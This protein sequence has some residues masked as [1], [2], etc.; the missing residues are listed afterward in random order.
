MRAR[1]CHCDRVP[2]PGVPFAAGKGWC[3]RC[4]LYHNDSR[5]RDLWTPKPGRAA[6]VAARIPPPKPAPPIRLPCVHEGAVKSKCPCGDES[7]DVRWCELHK[8]GVK[9]AGVCRTCGDYARRLPAPPPTVAAAGPVEAAAYPHAGDGWTRHLLWFCY[10][11]ANTSVWQCNVDQLLERIALFN[12]RRVCA[13]AKQA[14]KVNPRRESRKRRPAHFVDPPEA[15]RARL[16]GHRFEF[17]EIDNDLKLGEVAAFEPLWAMVEPFREPGDVTFYYHAK[18]VTRPVNPGVSVHPW[19]SALYGANLDHWPLVAAQLK[20]HPIVGA[21]KKLGRFGS[22]ARMHYSGTAYWFRNAD[23]FARDWRRIDRIYAGV[24]AWPGVQFTPDEMGCVFWDNAGNL[25]D[26]AYLRTA[27]AAYR[28]WSDA[29][30]ARGQRRPG[31]VSN[32]WFAH[33]RYE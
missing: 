6:R 12:G 33:H 11:V 9:R 24:E 16:A 20:A 28:D 5:Y 4:D 30:A 32:P 22:A 21:F 18:G 13:I 1:P 29:A 7:R 14:G 26:F 23:V 3:R 25:Y 8:A 31:A 17:V 27:L 15:V 10:P 2:P 19:A